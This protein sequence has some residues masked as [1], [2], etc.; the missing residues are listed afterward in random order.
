MLVYLVAFKTISIYKIWNQQNFFSPSRVGYFSLTIYFTFLF[1]TLRQLSQVISFSFQFLI[2]N[3]NIFIKWRNLGYFFA[4][5][6]ESTS[7]FNIKNYFV[8]Q[9]KL[10]D[11]CHG[12]CW[13]GWW[14][15]TMVVV[16]FFVLTGY[17]MSPVGWIVNKN[18]IIVIS[19]RRL[20]RPFSPKVF[21]SFELYCPV[22][23][24]FLGLCGGYLPHAGLVWNLF[25]I[26]F[27]KTTR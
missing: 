10:N 15:H 25:R 18:A 4:L 17:L 20:S 9:M 19:M 2:I 7:I 27:F 5:K 26:F 8:F 11:Y 12:L 14:N 24:V 6:N 13:G 22:L 23:C 1:T 21:L 16:D 3:V